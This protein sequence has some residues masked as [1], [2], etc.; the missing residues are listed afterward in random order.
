MIVN[1]EQIYLQNGHWQTDKT[2]ESTHTFRRAFFSK[3]RSWIDTPLIIAIQGL[4]RVGKSVLVE[5]LKDEFIKLKKLRNIHFLNFSFDKDDFLD[6]YES[7]ELEKLLDYY[8]TKII[9]QHAGLVQDEILI[10][11]DE[12]QNVKGWQRVLKKYY[13][14]NKKIKFIISG[15][16]ELFLKDTSESLAGRIMEFSIPPLDFPEFCSLVGYTT[17]KFPNSFQEINNIIPTQITGEQ[18][19]LFEA[20]LLI[21]GFPEAVTMWQKSGSIRNSQ[22]YIKNS[23]IKKIVAQDLKRYF[24]HKT[25]LEDLKL[26]D[27][28]CNDSGAIIN[29]KKLAMLV[30]FSEETIK[31]HLIALEKSSLIIRLSQWNTKPRKVISA[32]PK[33]YCSTPS[34]ITSQLGIT[35]IPKGSQI[36][37]IVEGYI[38]MRV[39]NLIDSEIY[40]ARNPQNH[41]I[42]FYIPK[43]K[44]LIEAKYSNKNL[45]SDE[46]SFLINTANIFKLSSYIFTKE[47]WE[48][49]DE[50]FKGKII[51][52][53]LI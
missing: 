49:L 11:L 8:F 50:D 30:N 32:H 39:K 29:L 20:F 18:L 51:P 38:Y 17:I 4:R 1:T 7:A 3:I 19:A 26:F 13:D 12:I 35:E 21:G 14:L 33:Y 24:N 16:S 43:E 15:S 34:L 45:I 22:E 2:I 41:E 46:F 5:Q 47:G 44:V 27:I 25:T 40:Y 52:C 28:L 9:N 53:C 31:Q 36:G 23:I 48:M 37:H 42:D 10:V 6:L